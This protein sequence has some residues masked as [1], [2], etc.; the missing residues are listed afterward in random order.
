MLSAV[1]VSIDE[2]QKCHQTLSIMVKSSYETDAEKAR[3]A[4]IIQSLL[5][6]IDELKRL[7]DDIRAT[8][9]PEDQRESVVRRIINETPAFTPLPEDMLALLMRDVDLSWELTEQL[10]D[11]RLGDHNDVG[12]YL[13]LY[14]HVVTEFDSDRGWDLIC[15][16][17]GHADG[18][19]EYTHAYTIHGEQ[20]M[21]RILFDGFASPGHK[22]MICR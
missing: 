20:R 16:L 3:L 14:E 17:V 15:E 5:V 21:L 12:R 9:V 2:I 4:A 8:F 11:L 19:F 6:P 22:F 18:P 7:S 13:E 1:M 10:T